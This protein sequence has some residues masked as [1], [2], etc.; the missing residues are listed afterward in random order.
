MKKSTVKTFNWI[1]FGMIPAIIVLI[2][3]AFGIFAASAINSPT[4]NYDYVTPKTESGELWRVLEVVEGEYAYVI[5][6]VDDVYRFD[7][8]RLIAF[9]GPSIDAIKEE[10]E[11]SNDGGNGIT[12]YWEGKGVKFDFSTTNDFEEYLEDVESSVYYNLEPDAEVIT[13]NFSEVTLYEVSDYIGFERQNNSGVALGIMI[14]VGVIVFWTVIVLAVEL[15]IAII[16]K[17]TV[18]KVKKAQ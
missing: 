8:E 15:L 5:Y 14:L 18:F 13:S 9:Q 11:E 7:G 2:A 1:A 4:I 17:L 16:L 10:V 6:S 12:S 3:V